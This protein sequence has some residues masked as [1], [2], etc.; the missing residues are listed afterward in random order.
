MLNVSNFDIL[1]G[2]QKSKSINTTEHLILLS[3]AESDKHG[4][5]IMKHISE[6]TKNTQQLGPGSLYGNIK[7]L[8]EKNFINE[9]KQ[10]KRRKYYGLTTAGLDALSDATIPMIHLANYSVER[11]GYDR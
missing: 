7:S 10:T 11:L 1:K 5:D 9:K 2:M 6:I 3:L 8:L 4:Y